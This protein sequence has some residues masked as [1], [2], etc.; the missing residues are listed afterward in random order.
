[1]TTKTRLTIK[2]EKFAQNLFIGLGQAESYRISGYDTK[3]QAP[4]TIYANASR[5][6]NNAKVLQRIDALQAETASKNVADETERKVSLTEV[7]RAPIEG[8]VTAGH[9]ISANAELNKMEHIYDAVPPGY[10][11]N[12]VINIIVL[13]KEAKELTEGVGKFGI[14]NRVKELTEGEE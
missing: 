13:D 7:I 14:F 8:P 1:M 6:A 4:T 11:D 3:N 2:Q 12:R 5:L 10:Q 9:R